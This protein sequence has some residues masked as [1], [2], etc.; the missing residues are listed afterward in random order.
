V[1]LHAGWRRELVRQLGDGG[2]LVMHTVGT[3][4]Q[5]RRTLETQLFGLGWPMRHRVVPNAATDRWCRADPMGPRAIRALHRLSTPLAR[6]PM[7][8][9]A[10]THRRQRPEIPLFGPIAPL[11]G[12]PDELVQASALYAGETALRIESLRPAARVV[13]ELA[14]AADALQS[15]TISSS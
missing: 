13:A 11:Q 14:G 4:A 5:A 12:M 2:A 1:V 10:R 8:V 9:G 3:P 6:L 15:P 7:S